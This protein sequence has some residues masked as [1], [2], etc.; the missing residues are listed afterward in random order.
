MRMAWYILNVKHAAGDE[1]YL[2]PRVKYCVRKI[3]D[4]CLR[5]VAHQNG[6]VAAEIIHRPPYS[7]ND[8]GFMLDCRDQRTLFS[9]IYK[10]L[11]YLQRMGAFVVTPASM[12]SIDAKLIDSQTFLLGVPV[13]D[14]EKAIEYQ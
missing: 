14:H 11:L 5:F 1:K 8:L 10:Q 3:N 12:E 9:T 13:I 4:Y 2:R 6:D 7:E